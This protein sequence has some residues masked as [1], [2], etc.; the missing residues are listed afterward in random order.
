VQ[1]QPRTR[2][3]EAQE[4]ASDFWTRVRTNVWRS[5]GLAAFSLL[6][7]IVLW[8]VVTDA[9]NPTRIDTFPS[10]IQVEAVNVR[11]GLAVANA[12]L[13]KVQVRVAAPEDRWD[14]LT[15]ANFRA[16]VDLNELTAREQTVPVQVEITGVSRARVVDTIPSVVVVNLEPQQTK[17]VPVTTRIV[18]APPR[19]YEA[20]AAVSEV[21]SV[22][23]SGPQSLVSEVKEAVAAVN[24]TGL[25]VGLEQTVSLVPAVEGGGEIRG[26]TLRPETVKVSI[27][28][29]QSTLTRTLPVEASIT[30]DP[31]PGYRVSGVKVTPS[32]LQ[33][34]GTIDV[35]Q[36]LD[37]LKLPG[38]DI[39]GQVTDVKSTV[40]PDP[41]EGLTIV[42]SGAVVTVEVT[43][44]AIPGSISL[45][46]APEVTNVRQ[47]LVA[48][49]NPGSVTAIAEGPLPRLNAM[50]PGSIRAT[51]DAS[52]LGPG[53]TDIR[54]EVT[55]PEGVSIRQ[56]Q[57]STVSVTLAPP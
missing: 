41:P 50:Q 1:A 49:V 15:E 29:T 5:P 26:V 10:E 12:S 16:V 25:T 35:L 20:G 34:E 11:D 6:I 24:V 38:V 54:V 57:P 42:P 44:T 53:T 45:T 22:Q 47:G 33:V 23:V 18:G 4:I 9:E 17:E 37:T 27:S 28:I 31:A 56:V 55:A 48:R 7:G 46:L 3:R 14:E 39:G 32:T 2:L 43:I 36:A 30:G 52:N 40:R 8:L 13:P 51:V 21:E 19:G